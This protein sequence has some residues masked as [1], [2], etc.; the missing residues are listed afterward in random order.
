MGKKANPAVIGAFVVGAIALAVAGLLIFG[1]GRMFR[2]TL[3]FVCF[4]P[5]QVNGLSVGA[6]VK[7]KGVDIG[8]VTDIR[9]R[10]GAEKL[11]TAKTVSEGIRIPVLI[12]IDQE[13]LKGLG[14]KRLDLQ[15]VKELVD[16]G[17][18]AQ[19]ATQSFVT[20]LL[21]VDLDFHPEKPAVYF[22]PPGSREQEIPTV[23]TGLEEVRSVAEE[24]FRKLDELHLNDIVKSASEA[25]DGI[26]RLVNSPAMKETIDKLP[27]TVINV[28][29]TLTSVREATARLAGKDGTIDDIRTVSRQTDATLQQVRETLE[30][31]QALLDP[32]APLASDLATSLRELASAARAVRLLANY[33]ER[34]PGALVRG[35]E[36]KAK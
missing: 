5:W 20:G 16:L 28:N 33:V 31:V 7:F 13:K 6:P 4:F 14:A 32:N 9:I 23:Q 1:S 10:F 11:A 35:K 36:V 25:L 2:H 22:L 12:E 27:A 21:Y 29:Q 18:R 26:K 15:R 30:T 8:S 19:L 17:L 34:N 3:Q 24:V